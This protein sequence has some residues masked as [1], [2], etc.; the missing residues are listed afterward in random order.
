MYLAFSCLQGALSSY[1][2]RS[3]Q[4]WFWSVLENNY[5]CLCEAFPRVPL[6]E[7]KPN[8][9]NRQQLRKDLKGHRGL[10]LCI[11]VEIQDTGVALS[12]YDASWGGKQTEN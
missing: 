7:T 12:Y 10:Q 11:L 6:P 4:G 2:I 1:R 3:L 8:M 5:Y 9:G